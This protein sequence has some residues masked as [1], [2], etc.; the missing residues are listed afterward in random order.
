ME[1][2]KGKMSFGKLIHWGINLGVHELDFVK[3]CVGFPFHTRQLSSSQWTFTATA[4]KS[5]Q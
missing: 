2:L 3:G 5:L 1:V 4:A